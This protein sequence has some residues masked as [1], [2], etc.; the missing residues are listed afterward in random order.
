MVELDRD[1]G[2]VGDP[3]TLTVPP[4]ADLPLSL[5]VKCVRVCDIGTY[6]DTLTVGE[7]EVLEEL[8]PELLVCR[9]CHELCKD[10]VGPGTLSV[11]ATVTPVQWLPTRPAIVSR[12]VTTL[13][14][15]V[16]VWYFA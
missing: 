12:D 4:L 15:C 14:V 5:Q 8:L 9:P 3:C 2:Q 16:C 1:G 7:N 13:Q 6:E 10:C 11:G